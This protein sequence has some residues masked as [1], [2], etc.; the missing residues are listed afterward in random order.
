MSSTE[1]VVPA[2]LTWVKVHGGRGFAQMVNWDLD[3]EGLDDP[4]VGQHVIA[5]DGGSERLDAVIVE[6]RDNGT[7]VLDFPAYASEPA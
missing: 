7:L 1:V 4:A 2:D 5:A 6:V 3:D